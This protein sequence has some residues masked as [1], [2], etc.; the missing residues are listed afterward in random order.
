L[1]EA[2]DKAFDGV[3]GVAVHRGTIFDVEC[4]A[5]VSLPTALAL[6][7]AASMRLIRPGL[8]GMCNS[9]YAA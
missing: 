6:W 8:A 4:D 3:V 7:L 2:W 1:A 9:G 5:L